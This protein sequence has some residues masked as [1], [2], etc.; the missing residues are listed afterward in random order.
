M[1]T[2]GKARMAQDSS[3]KENKSTLPTRVL[4]PLGRAP[5]LKATRAALNSSAVAGFLSP[6]PSSL[7]ASA[8]EYRPWGALPELCCTPERARRSLRPLA[9]HCLLPVPSSLAEGRVQLLGHSFEVV[10]LSLLWLLREQVWRKWS[11][12]QGWL[13][14]TVHLRF[15]FFPLFCGAGD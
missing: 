13:A 10:T 2:Q 14:L 15:S 3:L 5:K 4:N 9:S 8:S 1:S 12:I 6:Q 11:Q 7:P